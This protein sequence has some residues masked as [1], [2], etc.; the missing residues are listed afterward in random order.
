MAF[1][2]NSDKYLSFNDFLADVSITYELGV[3]AGDTDTRYG[4]VYFN[5]LSEAKPEIAEQLRATDLDPFH[6][7]NILP[8]THNFVESRW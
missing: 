5:F 7:D 3:R 1:S 6:R 4:Q 8:G 2:K